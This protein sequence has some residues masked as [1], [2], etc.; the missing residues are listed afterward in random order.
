MRGAA[1]RDGGLGGEFLGH[2]RATDAL[3]HVVR[4]FDDDVG[5][6]SDGRVDPVADAETVD[7]EL[8]LAD[9]RSSS[10]GASAPSAPRAWARSARGTSSRCSTAWSRTSTRASP[11][12]TFDG[13]MPDGLDLLTRK[14]VDLRRERQRGGRPRARRRADRLRAEHGA[15]VVA[16]AARFEAELAEIDDPEEREAFLADLGLD[17]PGMPRLARAASGRSA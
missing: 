14:P 2:L 17:E 7:L 10:A 5:P 1:P 13:A 11:A 6:T 12:R 8:V 15:E 16:V 9:Q 3:A 4:C